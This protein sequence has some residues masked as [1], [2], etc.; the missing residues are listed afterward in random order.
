MTR[1]EIIKHLHEA[2]DYVDIHFPYRYVFVEAIEAL[3]R[4]SLSNL[5]EAAEEYSLDVKAKPYGNLVKEAFK[6]GATWRDA[7]IPS[8]PSNLDEAAEEYGRKEYSHA[9][10]FWDEGLS[11]NKP[12]V[13]KKDFVDSFKAGAEWMAGQ[14]QKI[15]GEL[16]DWYSTSDGKDYCCGVRSKDA[17]E[18]P[19]GFYIKKKEIVL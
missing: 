19:E 11:K 7:Q 15:E 4:P 12:E 14:F 6:G 8:L 17:F 18:V 16:V 10:H 2:L 13:M 9:I 3:S 5:G 1:E